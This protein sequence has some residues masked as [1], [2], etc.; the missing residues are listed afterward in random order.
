MKLSII[1]LLALMLLSGCEADLKSRYI[2]SERG[3]L[4]YNYGYCVLGVLTNNSMVNIYDE[5]K[6][7]IKCSGY[8]DLTKAEKENYNSLSG[9]IE[10]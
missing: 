3:L 7:P 1:C 4:K 8:I 5:N 10:C 2:V 6:K 9:D